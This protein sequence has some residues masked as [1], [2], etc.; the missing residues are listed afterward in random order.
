MYSF[1]VLLPLTLIT[2]ALGSVLVFSPQ[3]RDYVDFIGTLDGNLDKSRLAI[4]I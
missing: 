4:Q 2:A 3:V 1:L